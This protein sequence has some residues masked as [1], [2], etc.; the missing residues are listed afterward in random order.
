MAILSNINDKFAVDSSGGIQFSGQTGTSGYVLKSNG[1][2]APTW[3]APSTIIG[4]PYL[5]L[6]GGTLSGPLAG[7]SATFS[8]IITANSSSSGDYVRLYGSSGTGKWDIYGNGANLRISDNES[9]GILAVDTAISV[10]GQTFVD[11]A[12]TNYDITMPNGIA[13]GGAAYTYCNIFGSGGNMTIAANAYPAN[14]GN[15]S[16]ITFKTASVGGG[17][18]VPMVINGDKVG[19]GTTS[20]PV[21]LSIN[22]WSYNPGAAAGAGMI[23]IKQ[24]DNSPYGFVAEASLSLIHILTLPTKRI[25]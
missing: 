5:P 2:A 1:N 11:S 10:K 25:V 4:G 3:V 19:I 18:F 20:P 14:S 15:V 12:N 21:K 23:G 6:T 17:T 16:T 24:G 9:A 13:F 22:G 7:T 8:G